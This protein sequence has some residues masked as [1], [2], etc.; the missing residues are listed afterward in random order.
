[1]TLRYG[2]LDDFSHPFSTVH[3]VAKRLALPYTSVRR[4]LLLFEERGHTFSLGSAKRA[5][6]QC[7]PESMQQALVSRDVCEAWKAYTLK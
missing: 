1:M 6:F 5:E 4:F 3:S 7:I 2:S